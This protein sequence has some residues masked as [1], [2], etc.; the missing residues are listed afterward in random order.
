MKTI[1]YILTFC[2]SAFLAF[3][4]IS[5]LTLAVLFLLLATGCGSTN[6]TT[7][8]K[9]DASGNI[10]EVRENDSDISD[11]QSYIKSGDN[12]STVVSIAATNFSI[13]QNGLKYFSVEGTRVKAIKD[14]EKELTQAAEIIKATKTKIDS[15]SI[16]VN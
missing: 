13:N 1:N 9:Y 16:K 5:S 4:F 8:T 3:G 15:E 14:T 2:T 7:V 6:K 11:F 12:A 10:V